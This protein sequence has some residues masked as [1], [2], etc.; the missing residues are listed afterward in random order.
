M[1][2]SYLGDNLIF[3]ISQP[4][5]GSTLLQR[6]LGSHSAIAISSEP[7]LMLHPVYG[8]RDKGIETD[9]SADWAA[10][11]LN[12]FLENYTDGPQVYDDGIR[13]FA[14]TIYFNAMAKGD[15]RWFID[16]TPRYLLILDDLLRLFPQAKFV[17]LLRNPMSVLSSLVNTQVNHDLYTLERFREE[18][19]D[20]PKNMLAAIEKLGDQATV[21]RYE[22]FVLAPE[23]ESARL[24][25][26]F[27][28]DYEQ[29]MVDYA[30]SEPVK[31]FMQDRTGIH[32]H[33]RPSDTRIE[34]WR[35][36][37]TDA[38]QIHFAQH[39]LR[40]LGRE[41]VEKLGYSYDELNDAI[42]A[43]AERNRSGRVLLPWRVALLHP[44]DL[45]GRDQQAVTLYRNTRDHGALLGHLKT[46][47]AFWGGAWKSLKFMFGRSGV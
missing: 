22:E 30:E 37:L 24:C 25:A 13:A 18:L 35:Q 32:Q 14:Q 12:E 1:S 8:T 43:A 23:K 42:R 46:I 15:G 36:M 5:A 6:I 34:S 9:Y 41:T 19:L 47:A 40:D 38:Q 26:E 31:G 44:Q 45:R 28:I 16:K 27:G 39:Y 2:M 21:V 10:R 3:I 33:D 29:G 7:W 17:F 11:G 20:G 4:R